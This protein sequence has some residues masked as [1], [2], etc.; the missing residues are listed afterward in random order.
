MGNSLLHKVYELVQDQLA[1]VAEAVE[2]RMQR[3]RLLAQAVA[4]A[5]NP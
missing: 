3:P 1:K 2:A 4:V 5:E